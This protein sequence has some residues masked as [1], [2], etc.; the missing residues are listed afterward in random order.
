VTHAR[1]RTAAA[2]REQLGHPIV[3]ADGHWLEFGPAMRER[4]RRVGGERAVQGFNAA[5]KRAAVWAGSSLQE[6]IQRRQPQEAFWNFSSDTTDRATA[7]MPRLF[8]ER[9]DELGIDFAVVYPTAGLPVPRVPE[10][11]LRQAA[12]R[13]YNVIVAEEFGPYADRLTPA[14]IIPMVTPDEAIAELEYVTRELG[15]K[16]AMM[17]SLIRRLLPSV[18]DQPDGG[19]IAE[20]Y[21]VLGLDSL[22][23]YDRVWEACKRLGI[24]PTFH[25]GARWQGFRLSPSN[26]VY[27]HI[28]N[29]ATASEAVCKALFLGGVTRRFPELRFAF[30]EGGVGFANLLFGDLIGHWHKR[31]AE[32]LLRTKPGLLKAGVLLELAQRY[33]TGEL[34]AKLLEVGGRIETDA[35]NVT[36]GLAVLDD[37]AAAKIAR[38]DDFVPLFADSFYF[39]CEADDR[40]NAIAFDRRLNPL[41]VRLNAMFS[42]DIGHFDVPDIKEVV[43]E[44]YELLEDGLLTTDDM[45]DFTFANAVRFWGATNPAFFTGTCVEREATAV[46]RADAAPRQT[47]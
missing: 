25:T 7:M 9:L 4:M 22:Y 33:S 34:R 27:N 28:G 41:G 31:G 47:A 10:P 37:Y 6:R 11:E 17:G 35:D 12:C 18:V 43:P 14:A 20:W 32:G 16:V 3:D 5:H 19:R 21:D 24:S 26:F 8:Y 39:G 44:A 13:A 40:A 42:S 30:L 46:L 45:R 36:G 15:L 1:A 29:F 23:D 2:V 38:V